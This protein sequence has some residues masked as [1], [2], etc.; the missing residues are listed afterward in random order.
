MLLDQASGRLH[1]VSEAHLTEAVLS[2][3]HL[4][5]ELYNT[6]MNILD[7]VHNTAFQLIC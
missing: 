2:L 4:L 6:E 1:V 7:E 3:L 5:G